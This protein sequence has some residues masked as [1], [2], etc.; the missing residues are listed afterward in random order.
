MITVQRCLL[1][2]LL[3]TGVN[4]QEANNQNAP[5]KREIRVQNIDAEKAARALR[6]LI[7][8]V[9]AL[10]NKGTLLL[11]CDRE[12]LDDIE[13]LLSSVDRPKAHIRTKFVGTQSLDPAKIALVLAAHFS[14][15]PGLQVVPQ[16]AQKRVFLM[17]RPIDI[18]LAEGLIAEQ[19][20][21]MRNKKLR[22]Q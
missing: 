7:D 16:K 1:L 18:A 22:A 10:P 20:G 4:A 5:I 21:T 9:V 8:G 3:L 6:G 14:E 17:G 13:T 11:T 2:L 19:N 12:K 15:D